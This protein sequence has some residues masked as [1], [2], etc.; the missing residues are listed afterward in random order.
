MY[1]LSK[2]LLLSALSIFV[3]KTPFT[4]NVLHCRNYLKQK[5]RR[6][7]GFWVKLVP[8]DN[9]RNQDFFSVIKASSQRILPMNVLLLFVLIC[10]RNILNILSYQVSSQGSAKKF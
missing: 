2:H 8:L 1:L 9:Y 10:K 5:G 4:H 7:N 6:F 3:Q